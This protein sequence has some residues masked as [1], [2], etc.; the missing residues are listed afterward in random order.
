MSKNK[1]HKNFPA[2]VAP[3]PVTKQNSV[4]SG[5]M[6]LHAESQHISITRSNMPDVEML[7]GYARVIPGG[8]DRLMA[9]IE[10]QTAHRIELEKNVIPEQIKQANR[11]QIFGFVLAILAFATG[12]IFLFKG[13]PYWG[14][15]ICTSTVVA[16]AS[17][18]VMGKVKVGKNLE[19]KKPNQPKQENS[20]RI[21]NN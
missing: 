16:L 7:E 10:Q 13:H 20:R 11:G 1:H 4:E 21:E 15:A 19:T 12:I 3:A 14:G 9:L 5:K 17:L 2:K 18:F 8:A 6:V